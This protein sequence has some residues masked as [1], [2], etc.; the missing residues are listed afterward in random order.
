VVYRKKSCDLEGP[1]YDD[2]VE[3]ALCF[4]WID[5]V[6][7][8]VDEDRMIQWFSPRRPRGMWSALNKERIESLERDGLMTAAG[9]SVIDRAR[10][11]GSWS[12]TDQVDALIIPPDLE[13]AF[14]DSPAARMVYVSLPDATKKQL[15]WAIYSAKRPETRARRLAD[16][17]RQLLIR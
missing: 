4:G 1:T 11:D 2:L 13:A 12:Q 17:I 9:R 3:E 7:R 5:S 6:T 8:R 16:V 10:A 15:L 14:D